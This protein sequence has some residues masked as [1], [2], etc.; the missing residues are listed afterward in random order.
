ML[1]EKMLKTDPQA[2]RTDF[3]LSRRRS[4]QLISMKPGR[5]QGFGVGRG[6]MKMAG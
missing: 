3:T 2:K 6:P 1:G 5:Q 4:R